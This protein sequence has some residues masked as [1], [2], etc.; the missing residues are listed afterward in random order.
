MSV[1][2]ASSTWPIFEPSATTIRREADASMRFLISASGALMFVTPRLAS[3]PLHPMNTVSALV[4]EQVPRHRI[5][6]GV[7]QAA[8]RPAGDDHG[9]PRDRRLQLEGDVQPVREYHQVLQI[10]DAR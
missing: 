1:T 9:E 2:Q 10:I 4:P 8:Q 7:L 5:H 3:T 6:Q